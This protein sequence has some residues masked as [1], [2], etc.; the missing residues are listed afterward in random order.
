MMGST[1]ERQCGLMSHNDWGSFLL[2]VRR[3]SARTRV[4]KIWPTIFAHAAISLGGANT[5]V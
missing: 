3:T 1:V 5:A 4:V 2:V